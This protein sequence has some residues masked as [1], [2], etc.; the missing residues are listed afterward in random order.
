MKVYLAAI[1]FPFLVENMIWR[2]HV[3]QKIN[4]KFFADQ[5]RPALG[6]IGC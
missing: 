4:V 5:V 2:D 3:L 1:R 6:S